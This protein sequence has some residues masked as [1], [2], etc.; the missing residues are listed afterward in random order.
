MLIDLEIFWFDMQLTKILMTL[1]CHKNDKND[2]NSQKSIKSQKILKVSNKT[3]NF[4]KKPRYSQKHI[5]HKN[6]KINQ[7]LPQVLEKF[8][9]HETLKKAKSQKS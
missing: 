1:G 9:T 6:F 7:K 4:S 8:K 2:K 5:N 3:S